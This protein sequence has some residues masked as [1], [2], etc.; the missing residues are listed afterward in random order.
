LLAAHGAVL[1][2]NGDEQ[3]GVWRRALVAVA[4]QTTAHA[5]IAGLATRLAL[6]DGV[7]T[8]DDAALALGLQ[9]SPGAD[10]GRAAAWLEGFLNRNAQVL[11]HDETVWRL[12][13]QWLSTLG[14]EH[15][16]RVLPLVRRTFATFGPGE[17]RDLGA[18]ARRAVGGTVVTPGAQP[19]WDDALAALAIPVLRQIFGLPS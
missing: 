5:L 19:Q 9:L 11:L 1:L 14:D 2:R 6:D 4:G 15:F 10:P 12:V 13:D 8:G 16:M 3:T 7:L 17:R 18:R